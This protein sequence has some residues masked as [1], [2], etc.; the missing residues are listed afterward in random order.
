MSVNGLDGISQARRKRTKVKS[1]AP[2]ETQ[3]D[4]IQNVHVQR[5]QQSD[6]AL[7]PARHRD[8]NLFMSYATRAAQQVHAPQRRRGEAHRA[9]DVHGVTEHV[10]REALDAMVH[11]DAEIIA[12]ERARDAERPRRAH[13]ERLARDEERHGHEH[14]ER[15][16]E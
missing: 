13:D 8:V 2:L 7:V 14:V 9:A 5:H 3:S 1:S 16:G 12:E 15:S 6:R 4:R 11:Q 10:E